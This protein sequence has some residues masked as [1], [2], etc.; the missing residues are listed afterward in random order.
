MA[1]R[2][3][4]EKITCRYFKWILV[5][6]GR[7]F[8][9]DGRSNPINAGRH[10]ITSADREE[11][12]RQ[13]REL[14]EL[15]AIKLSLAKAED[16]PPTKCDE[17]SLEE[18]RDLYLEHVSRP[19]VTGGVKPSTKKRYRSIF[20]KFLVF[21]TRKGKRHWHEVTGDLL[22]GYAAD[23]ERKEF[24]DR[25]LYIELTTLKQTVRWLIK[26]K[27]LPPD[28]AI[29][30]PLDKPQGTSTYCWTHEQVT[31]MIEHCK[32]NAEL[33]WLEGV[34]VALATTGLR[35]GELV[36]LRWTDLQLQTESPMI[37]LVDETAKK[38]PRGRKRRSTKSGRDRMLPLFKL[39]SNQLDAIS[40][41]SDGYVFHGPKGGRLKPDTVRRVLIRDVLEPLKVRFRSNDDDVGFREGRPHSFRHYFCTLCV[42]LNV[43]MHV[44]M[45]WLGHSD[46]RM[47]RHYYHL[48]DAESR[49]HSQEVDRF[50]DMLGTPGSEKSDSGSS[51][52]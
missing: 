20:D 44:V 47:V 7:Y 18:G 37:R 43:P 13:L 25:T 32:K 40:R 41:H 3:S 33:K 4:G 49:R 39:L 1:R 52:Q 24:A 14:D 34:V 2:R 30:L 23:L 11:A 16:H 36:E 46:S 15:I 27:L 50:F 5:R 28:S 9:A 26:R 29:D 8:Q 12:L 6:R 21:A 48:K 19:R 17:I 51:M 22:Q 35:I 45:A 38:Q 42:D 10:S 31:A